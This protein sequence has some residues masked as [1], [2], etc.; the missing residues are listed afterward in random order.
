MWRFSVIKNF[1]RRIDTIDRKCEFNHRNWCRAMY[2]DSRNK[3][4][5]LPR[6]KMWTFRIRYIIT[7]SMCHH[8]HYNCVHYQ[9]SL[10]KLISWILSTTNYRVGF[11][12]TIH[13]THH[14]LHNT[15]L[16]LRDVCSWQIPMT[17]H[18][19]TLLIWSFLN[20]SSNFWMISIFKITIA[21]PTHHYHDYYYVQDPNLRD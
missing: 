14:N 15:E 9:D 20:K 16:L 11:G 17:L 18:L 8:I 6:W 19:I 4:K 5:K 13:L 2:R 7:I 21:I 1:Q 10:C 3:N 12:L